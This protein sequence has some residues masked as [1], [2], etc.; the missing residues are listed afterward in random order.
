M[1]YAYVMSEIMLS[2]CG[3]LSMYF[4]NMTRLVFI[5]WEIVN[6]FL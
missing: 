6:V 2:Y 1:I 4:C 5:V 3:K